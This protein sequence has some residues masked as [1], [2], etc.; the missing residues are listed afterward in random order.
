V[1]THCRD[2]EGPISKCRL[3]YVD[4]VITML[5]LLVFTL[6][7]IKQEEQM[8]LSPLGANDEDR[9]TDPPQD[10]ESEERGE[11]RQRAADSDP[12]LSTT[13]HDT[14]AEDGGEDMRNAELERCTFEIAAGEF[15]AARMDIGNVLRRQWWTV[16]GVAETVNNVTVAPRT[17]PNTRPGVSE[18]ENRRWTWRLRGLG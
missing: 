8:L 18:T 3:L 9:P 17:S 13:L 1:L 2:T 6:V 14:N 7:V 11:H 5:Q 15:E 4:L 10:V 12:L 16:G